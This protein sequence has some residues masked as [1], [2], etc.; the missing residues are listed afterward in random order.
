MINLYKGKLP[1]CPLFSER[2]PV[3]FSGACSMFLGM[4]FLNDFE[5][6]HSSFDE[7]QHFLENKTDFD[8]KNGQIWGQKWSKWQFYLKGG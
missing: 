3:G 7:K 1:I 4:A 6:L 2:A 5:K 8:K